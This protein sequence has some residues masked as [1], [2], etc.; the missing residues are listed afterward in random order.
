MNV[1]F[2][3]G[4]QGLLEFIEQCMVG[5]GEG[6]GWSNWLSLPDLDQKLRE[7]LLDGMMRPRENFY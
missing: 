6:K 1:I 4:I 2:C 3:G 5:H 7:F